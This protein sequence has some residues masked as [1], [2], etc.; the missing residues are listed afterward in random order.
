[1]E[2]IN[3]DLEGTIRKLNT[4][5]LHRQDN[6]T[7]HRSEHDVDDGAEENFNNTIK[8]DLDRTITGAESRPDLPVASNGT[9]ASGGGLDQTVIDD[10]QKTIRPGEM[11]YSRSVTGNEPNKEAISDLSLHEGATSTTEHADADDYI[12]TVPDGEQHF[13]LLLSDLFHIGTCL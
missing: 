7:D 6:K 8:H 12:T 3:E 13:P 11:Q 2:D 4:I 1:M 9:L 10:F 5:A